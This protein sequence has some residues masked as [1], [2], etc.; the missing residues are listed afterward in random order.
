MG[1]TVFLCLFG[2]VFA[3]AVL[4]LLDTRRQSTIRTMTK[5]L[6]E[7]E[8]D[9]I[10]CMQAWGGKY[11]LEHLNGHQSGWQ[12]MIILVLPTEIRFYPF[13]RQMDVYDRIPAESVRWFGRPKKYNRYNMNEMW[14]HYE[15]PDGWHVARIRLYYEL[16]LD[17]VRALKQILSLDLVTAYRRH[18]PYIFYGPSE[19]FPATQD[20]YGTWELADPMDILLTPMQLVFLRGQQVIKQILLRDIQQIKALHRVD[21]YDPRGL[22]RFQVGEESTV[23]AIRQF[24][25]FA[26]LLATAAKRTLEE[27]IQRKRK[28]HADEDDF[29][30]EDGDYIQQ[31]SPN[32]P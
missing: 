18:R 11:R 7:S 30:E 10:L 5:L 15:R 9:A 4:I 13:Q 1:E 31:V 22:I 20:L 26:D 8:P 21:N 29:L 19:I 17:F 28:K 12:P 25:E 16:M 24:E 2:G 32:T 14:I 27:P 3:I 23:F 6:E